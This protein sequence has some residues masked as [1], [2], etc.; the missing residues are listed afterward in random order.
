L[1]ATLDDEELLL[2]LFDPVLPHAAIPVAMKAAIA[3]A[4]ICFFF[5]ESL[6]SFKKLL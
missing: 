3:S 2:E 5:I 1:L 4:T 6:T